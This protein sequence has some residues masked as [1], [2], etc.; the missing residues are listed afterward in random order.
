MEHTDKGRSGWTPATASNDV[1]PAIIGAPTREQ[2]EAEKKR[3][4]AEQQALLAERQEEAFK[5]QKA[6]LLR[7]W[8]EFIVDRSQVEALATHDI[9]WAD[10]GFMLEFFVADYTPL[11]KLLIEDDILRKFS[12]FAK[13]VA[14]SPHNDGRKH[15]WQIGDI[16]HMGDAYMNVQVNPMWSAWIEGQKSNQRLMGKEPNKYI[17]LIYKLLVDGKAYAS[18]KA[19]Y[20]LTNKYTMLDE[21]SIRDFKGPYVFEFSGYDYESLTKRIKGNPW[22]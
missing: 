1:P 11:S 17:R 21:N 3:R 20:M 10:K 4:E 19:R 8:D 7:M 9:D 6:E 16:V 2:A 13:I 14:V 12:P 18:D 15:N 22:L 5:S